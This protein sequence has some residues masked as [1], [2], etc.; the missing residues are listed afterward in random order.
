MIYPLRLKAGDHIVHRA[1][2]EPWVWEEDQK[3]KVDMRDVIYM[4]M[5]GNW[6]MVR[7]PHCMPYVA[8]A[9]HCF[10]NLTEAGEYRPEPA[11]RAR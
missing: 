2:T 7:R 1:E 3:L 10:M 4:A 11:R 6:V 8:E 9:K 5:C